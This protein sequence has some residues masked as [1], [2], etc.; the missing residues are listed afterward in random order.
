MNWSLWDHPAVYAT[1]IIVARQRLR[2]HAPSARNT[3]VQDVLFP[4]RSLSQQAFGMQYWKKTSSS[5]QNLLFLSKIVWKVQDSDMDRTD[6]YWKFALLSFVTPG[7]LC[8]DHLMTHVH[9]TR[10]RDATR[11]VREWGGKQGKAEIETEETNKR[12]RGIYIY[13]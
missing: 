4:V 12:S 1:H 7:Q 2:K 5:S 8:V 13:I 9:R 11:F 3:Q 10:Q 6:D